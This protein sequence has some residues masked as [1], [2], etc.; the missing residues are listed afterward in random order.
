MPEIPPY[1]YHGASRHPSLTC[2]E[3]S[4]LVA[5]A[6]RGTTKEKKKLKIGVYLRSKAQH[7]NDTF[8]RG[9]HQSGKE[10]VYEELNGE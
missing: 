8:K 2:E 10:M 5:I 4:R 3:G 6:T 7:K 1:S 9:A